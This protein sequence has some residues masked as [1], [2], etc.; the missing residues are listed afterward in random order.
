MKRLRWV[1]FLLPVL[2]V[3]ISCNKEED[4]DYYTVLGTISITE[5]STIIVTD[6]DERLMVKGGSGISA[7][8]QDNDRVFVYFTFLDDF[9]PVGIDYVIE[10]YQIEE[11]LCKDI[12]E[13]TEANSDSIGHDAMSVDNLWVSKNYVNLSFK[14]YAN[15]ETH[16]I[17]LVRPEGEVPGDTVDL[18]IR[19][20]DNGDS[21]AYVMNGFVSFKLESVQNNLKDSV[22]LHITA[23]EYNDRRF[24]RYVTYKY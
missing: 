5:D 6:E 14:F 7:S 2:V 1:Y 10:L 23:K 11:I 16:I 21:E 8:I 9:K 19:H 3:L 13:L 17:N 20:N 12:I 22:I 18:E 4:K 15:T 24:D